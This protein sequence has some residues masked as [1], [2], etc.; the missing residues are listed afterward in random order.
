M[1][2]GTWSLA[3]LGALAL[4]AMGLVPAAWAVDVGQ[5]GAAE[6]TQSGTAAVSQ[7]GAAQGE[8]AQVAHSDA[9]QAA[10][11]EAPSAGAPTTAQPNAEQAVPEGATDANK[12]EAL[13]AGGSEGTQPAQPEN[14]AQSG[15]PGPG[16]VDTPIPDIQAVGEGDDSAMV[17]AT[18]AVVAGSSPTVPVTRT[19]V[20]GAGTWPFF[21][22]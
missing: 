5:S 10:A 7:V 17:G 1:K 6:A 9:A 14:A 13:R 16:L 21:P 22:A 11:P 18:V 19:H 12:A 15:E 2:C 4:P 8:D 20:P 3:V